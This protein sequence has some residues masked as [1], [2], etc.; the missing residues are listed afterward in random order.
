MRI[1]FVNMRA[2]KSA[3][4]IA[5]P[6]QRQLLLLFSLLLLGDCLSPPDSRA[7]GQPR[8][9]H[10]LGPASFLCLLCLLLRSSSFS[11]SLPAILL[12]LQL[13]AG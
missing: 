12:L 7:P 8:S 3:W 2:Y 13:F 9:S 1:A 11:P 4:L 5:A 6:N 10:H